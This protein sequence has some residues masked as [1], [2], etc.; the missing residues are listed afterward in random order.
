MRR[1]EFEEV[2]GRESEEASLREVKE[3]PEHGLEGGKGD[4]LE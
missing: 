1:G 3:G 2:I 4:G